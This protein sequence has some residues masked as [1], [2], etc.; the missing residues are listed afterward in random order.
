MMGAPE[1]SMLV[2]SQ[3]LRDGIMKFWINLFM[4]P[5]NPHNLAF[6]HMLCLTKGGG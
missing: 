2:T 1:V 5:F 6:L 3:R 4:Q